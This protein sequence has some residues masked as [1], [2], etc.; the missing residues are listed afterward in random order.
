MAMLDFFKKLVNLNEGDLDE[1]YDEAPEETIPVE[2]RPKRETP[3]R[4]AT[5][6]RGENSTTA[7]KV[8]I[9][10][11]EVYDEVAGIADQLVQGK[12]VVLNLETCNKDVS[13]RVVDF[14]AGA[15]YALARKPKK[16]ASN[17]FIILP[18]NADVSG[19]LSLDDFDEQNYYL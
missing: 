4:R 3:V 16:I 15:A 1:G 8:V 5:D 11:P 13:R 9:V 6:R 2:T 12:T 10:R 14:V 18:E 19:E 7:M 17:T